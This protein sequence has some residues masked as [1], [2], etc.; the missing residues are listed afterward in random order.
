VVCCASRDKITASATR[1]G[2]VTLLRLFTRIASTRHQR[3]CLHG[4][5]TPARTCA[6]CGAHPRAAPSPRL[7]SATARSASIIGLRS[8]PGTRETLQYLRSL[9]PRLPRATRRRTPLSTTR[10]CSFLR[11]LPRGIRRI[12]S[13]GVGRMAASATLPRRARRSQAGGS[14]GGKRRRAALWRTAHAHGDLAILPPLAWQQWRQPT[15]RVNNGACCI[16]LRG[17]L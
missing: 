1:T 15:S 12:H 2:D 8:Q 3:F 17:T 13:G 10:S 6:G 16:L 9:L 14:V 4:W 5:L 7:V 11:L